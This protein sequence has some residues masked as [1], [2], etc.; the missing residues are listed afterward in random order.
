MIVDTSAPSAPR[1]AVADDAGDAVACLEDAQ[2]GQEAQSGRHRGSGAAAGGTSARS[3]SGMEPRGGRRLG[4]QQHRR[5]GTAGDDAAL[6]ATL[7]GDVDLAPPVHL[8]YRGDGAVDEV[9][10]AEVVELHDRRRHLPQP[11]RRRPSSR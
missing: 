9:G 3:A 6:V 2:A 1:I 11:G 10:V 8:P 7:D 5:R 4:R